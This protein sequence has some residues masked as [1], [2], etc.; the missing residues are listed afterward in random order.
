MPLL[1]AKIYPNPPPPSSSAP[2]SLQ[3]RDLIHLISLPEAIF[4][5][6]AAR[7]LTDNPKKMLTIPEMELKKKEFD[8]EECGA[9]AL[10][11]A[12]PTSTEDPLI[13]PTL[14]IGSEMSL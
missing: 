3:N 1:Y 11:T 5:R 10:P 9:S 2:L 14:R 4:Q 12:L 6:E 8:L 13:D 7:K